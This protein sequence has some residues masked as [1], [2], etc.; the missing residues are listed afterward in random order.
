MG[1]T[2]LIP[3]FAITGMSIAIVSYIYYFFKSRHI[4]RMALIEND[5]DA[6]IFRI[7]ADEMQ[8]NSRFSG[9]KWGLLMTGIGMGI[10]FGRMFDVIFHSEP[11]GVFSGIMICG[12]LALVLHHV[13][14]NR[15]PNA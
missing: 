3:L 2:V 6:S 8:K 5:K 4:E 12:G 15:L 13:L 7:T 11:T 9:L 14:M 10:A 1:S